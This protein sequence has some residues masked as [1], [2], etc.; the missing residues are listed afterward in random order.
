[1]R[2]MV[3]F[4]FVSFFFSSTSE[5]LLFCYCFRFTFLN[6]DFAFLHIVTMLFDRKCLVSTDDIQENATE[7]LDTI[8]ENKLSNFNVLVFFSLICAFYLFNKCIDQ[9]KF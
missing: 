1:M 7:T 3:R 5:E 4:Q 2:R 6:F 8:D 9:F